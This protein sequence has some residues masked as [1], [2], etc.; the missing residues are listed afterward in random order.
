MKEK[1]DAVKLYQYNSFPKVVAIGGGTGLSTML[2]GLKKW[3]VNI[4]AIV[5]VADDGGGSGDLREN[6]GMLPPG[7]IRNCIMALADTETVME[8]LFTYRFD[9]GNLKGQSFGNLFLAAM[10]GI[11]GSF[12]KAV[13]KTCRVLA[14]KGRV[15]PVTEQNIYLEC[16]FR[17]GTSVFGES[18]ISEAKLKKNTDIDHIRLLPQNPAALPEA[19]EA[20]REAK[21]IILGPGSLYT[22]V[23]PNLLVDGICD[24]IKKSDALKVY[25]CNVMTQRGETE[26]Y[27]VSKH[28]EALY[29]HSFENI[30]DYCLVNDNTPPQK[31]LNKYKIQGCETVKIDDTVLSKMRIKLIKSD[32]L[33]ESGDLLRHDPDKLAGALMD[34]LYNN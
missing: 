6:L 4:T 1:V 12:S 31:L 15:L 14:V 24:E 5:T 27:T 16:M 8:D 9:S 10:N 32:F 21:L 23:I 13:E 25:V 18:K 2:R 29:K 28:L 3:S 11:C 30:V 7:D 34:L 26:N 19:L 22:S 17:D 20:I 33:T